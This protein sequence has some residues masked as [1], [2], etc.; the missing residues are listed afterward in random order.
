VCVCSREHP[1]LHRVV[2]FW[3]ICHINR[4]GTTD[5]SEKYIASIFSVVKYVRDGGA[6][7]SEA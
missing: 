6:S 7:M 1:S 2:V 5:F 3:I 4:H